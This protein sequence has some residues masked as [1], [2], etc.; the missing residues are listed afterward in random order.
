M[1]TPHPLLQI[2]LKKELTPFPQKP[3]NPVVPICVAYVSYEII[4]IQPS[5]YY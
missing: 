2:L 3:H 4:I 1:K 5:N